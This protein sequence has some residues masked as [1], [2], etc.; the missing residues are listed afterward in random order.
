LNSLSFYS[1]KHRITILG[2]FFI[3]FIFETCLG[4][5]GGF[6]KLGGGLTLRKVNT[7]VALLIS[8]FVIYQLKKVPRNIA[9]I[10]IAFVITLVIAVIIGFINY[11]Y[12][13]KIPENLLQQSFFLLLPFYS[14]FIR[15]E[16]DI[17]IVVRILKFASLSIALIYLGVLGLIAIGVV[18]FLEVY[19]IM[20]T[21]TE[22]MGRGESAFWFKGFLYLCLG[23]FFLIQRKKLFSN[24]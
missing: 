20:T 24:G 13:P 23:V 14:L 12:N 19:Q 16:A 4:G 18:S 3:L 7:F 10:F 1:T 6:I 22:F 8:L 9:Y 17:K 5:S 15:N 21:S 2:A 11:G